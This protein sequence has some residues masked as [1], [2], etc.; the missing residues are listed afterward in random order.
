MMFYT[1][2]IT[3]N[4]WKANYVLALPVAEK[5][6]SNNYVYVKKVG[7]QTYQICDNLEINSAKIL[8][9]CSNKSFFFMANVT[10]NLLSVFLVSLLD[11]TS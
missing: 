11:G 4:V 10:L 8:L 1:N 5:K 7:T 3:G 9:G 2:H 6:S